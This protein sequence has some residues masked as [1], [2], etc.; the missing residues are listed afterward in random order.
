MK[1]NWVENR[2]ELWRVGHSTLDCLI[3]S[4]SAL[5]W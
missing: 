2:V 3:G 5:F 1:E 4:F